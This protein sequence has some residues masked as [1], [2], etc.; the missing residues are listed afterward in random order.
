MTVKDL[1]RILSEEFERDAWGDFDPDLLK[2]VTGE[3]GEIDPDS[4]DAPN[5][6]AI[7]ELLTRVIERIENDR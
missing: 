4:D 2:Y 5:V 3:F 6:E 1:A 7:E